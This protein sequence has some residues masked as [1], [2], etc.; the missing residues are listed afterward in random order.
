MLLKQL[1]SNI[2]SL[3]Y[4]KVKQHYGWVEKSVAYEKAC[5]EKQISEDF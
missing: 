2:W 3:I 1:L 5:I 4:E